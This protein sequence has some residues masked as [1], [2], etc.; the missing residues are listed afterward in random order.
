MQE[1][2]KAPRRWPASARC[3][4]RTRTSCSQPRGRVLCPRLRSFPVHTRSQEHPCYSPVLTHPRVRPERSPV[5]SHPLVQHGFSTSHTRQQLPWHGPLLVRPGCC[6]G[7]THP[8][9]PGFL[10]TTHTRQHILPRS[11][12]HAPPRGSQRPFRSECKK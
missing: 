11:P 4:Q 9:H 10:P 8:V 1:S 5:H 12:V 3:L 7:L 2:G 6:P